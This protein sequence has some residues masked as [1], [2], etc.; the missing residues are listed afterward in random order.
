MQA[1]R[2]GGGT[3][4][5]RRE[6]VESVLHAVETHSREFLR[7]FGNGQDGRAAGIAATGVQRTIV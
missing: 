6:A 7:V 1:A 3:S 4:L 5:R 2:D